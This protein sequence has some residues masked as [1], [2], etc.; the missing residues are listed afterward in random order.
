MIMRHELQRSGLCEKYAGIQCSVFNVQRSVSSIHVV[1]YVTT[2][3][4]KISL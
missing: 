1:S 2:D 4:S 3:M